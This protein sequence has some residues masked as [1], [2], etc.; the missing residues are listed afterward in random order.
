MAECAFHRFEAEHGLLLAVC[1]RCGVPS[2]QRVRRQFSWYPRWL[3]VLVLVN[4]LVFAIVALV[5]TK[6]VT[7]EVPMCDR[8]RNHWL[9]RLL[10]NL[11]VFVGG[12]VVSGVAVW[13]AN[14]S[15]GP[16]AAGLAVL[17]VMVSLLGWLVTAA[18]CGQTAIR[19][20]KIAEHDF[21]LTGV[22]DG[23]LA[24]MSEHRAKNPL[25]YGTG[26]CPVT[27]W[28]AA[29][30]PAPVPGGM[31]PPPAG[32]YPPGGMYPPPMGMQPPAAGGMYPPPAGAYPPPGAY[33]APSPPPGNAGPPQW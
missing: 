5:M 14:R 27:G 25:P 20:T 7:V 16:D 33:P 9:K 18:I 2:S 22:A 30:P 1:L 24:A 32:L 11:G 3:V 31:Y 4:L 19:P 12:V 6:R 8:H 26:S 10:I 21:T 29:A 28:A 17:A 13:W 15:A 23:F